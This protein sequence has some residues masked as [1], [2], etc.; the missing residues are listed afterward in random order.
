MKKSNWKPY[1]AWIAATLAAG[2]LSAYLTRDGM[3]L[4]R[5]AIRKPPLSPPGIV[6]PIVWT[7]L[8]VLMGIGAAR[9]QIVSEPEERTP[10]LTLYVVQLIFNFLW[11]I[12]FFNQRWFG[13]S[14]LWLIALWVLILAMILKFRKI[15]RTA[16]L[17]QIPYLIWVS[18][19]AYLNAGVWLLNR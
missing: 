5:T 13:F 7:I 19:A 14:L 4:Y 2:A 11:S 6:F 16:A 9:V 3:E 12:F 10:H 18:F 17:L 15:E 1:A 8:Y